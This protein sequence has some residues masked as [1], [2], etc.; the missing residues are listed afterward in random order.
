METADAQSKPNFAK[1]TDSQKFIDSIDDAEDLS[2]DVLYHRVRNASEALVQWQNE[3]MD[4]DRF[5]EVTE[6]VG[7]TA[8]PHKNP[9]IPKDTQIGIGYR[10][11]LE[12]FVYGFEYQYHQTKVGKQNPSRQRYT[13][14][15]NGGRELRQRFP[16]QKAV[17]ADLS[18]SPDSDEGIGTRRRGRG[19]KLRE[20][21]ADVDSAGSR[22][23]RGRNNSRI[24]SQSRDQTPASTFPSGK[25]R[26]RPAK[27]KAGGA[28][29][30]Q[31][32]QLEEGF[33]YDSTPEPSH[34]QHTPNY[35][36]NPGSLA[37]RRS[38]G[39]HETLETTENWHDDTEQDEPASRP[40]TSDST[41]TGPS[42]DMRNPP[43][44]SSGRGR[45]RQNTSDFED[46]L[47]SHKRIRKINHPTA[48]GFSDLD[49]A[50]STKDGSNAE[51]TRNTRR[52]RQEED[53]LPG[54]LAA[55]EDTLAGSI[56]RLQDTQ[57]IRA[58]SGSKIESTI[59]KN[60]SGK[61]RKIITLKTSNG[62]PRTPANAVLARNATTDP[63]PGTSAQ[64][65]GKDGPKVSRASLN[66][67]RRWAAKKQAEALGL[68]VPKIGR[69]P[70]GG[71]APSTPDVAG[72][73]DPFNS[74]K[75]LG[76]RKRKRDEEE[77]NAANV[78]VSDAVA[79]TVEAPVIIKKR[80]GRPRKVANMEPPNVESTGQHM[81]LGG[82]RSNTLPSDK[83][84]TNLEEP[85]LEIVPKRKGGRPRKKPVE[86]DEGT[87]GT[88]NPVQD[89]QEGV[90]QNQQSS[91][92]SNDSHGKTEDTTAV[93][94]PQDA[95]S[96]NDEDLGSAA[97][98]EETVAPPQLRRTTRVRRQTS[99]ALSASSQANTRRSSRSS[100]K[101]TVTPTPAPTQQLAEETVIKQ[102]TVAGPALPRKRGRKPKSAK[103]D[104]TPDAT[105]IAT[106]VTEDEAPPPKRRKVTRT[107]TVMSTGSTPAPATASEEERATPQEESTVVQKPGTRKRNASIPDTPAP[108]VLS[109]GQATSAEPSL[110]RNRARKTPIT[111]TPVV[112]APSATPG[113]SVE[114]SVPKKRPGRPR[115]NPDVGATSGLLTDV[116]VKAEDVTRLPEPLTTRARS[117]GQ[118][119][120][121]K[122][123]PTEDF[124]TGRQA[125]DP[126]PPRKKGN[127]GGKRV[128]GVFSSGVVPKP[129]VA[130]GSDA[131]TGADGVE[132]QAQSKKL[133]ALDTTIQEAPKRGSLGG[134]RNK[135]AL[136]M[137]AAPSGVNDSAAGST[138]SAPVSPSRPKRV[139]SKVAAPTGEVGIH[140]EVSETS[141][142]APSRLKRVVTVAD[143]YAGETNL[144]SVV[145]GVLSSPPP[146]PRRAVTTT[147]APRG[148]ITI[149][150]TFPIAPST[151]PSRSKRAVPVA[152]GPEEAGEAD[153]DEAVPGG[154]SNAPSRPKRVVTMKISPAGALAA[155]DSETSPNA[156]IATESITTEPNRKVEGGKGTWGGRR[157]K[158]AKAPSLTVDE[159]I[160]TK[161]ES[162]NEDSDSEAT[163]KEKKKLAA[164]ASKSLKNSQSMKGKHLII[165][166]CGLF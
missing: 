1:L 37:R 121:A 10:D 46:A 22:A 19:Q 31:E 129:V 11:E 44:R 71:S 120:A 128:K 78:G 76:G 117:S 61:E 8:K 43:A 23:Q 94:L 115:K 2:Y 111:G 125:T 48:N 73:P 154:P 106:N 47:P 127:W 95:Q 27:P 32:L 155:D 157:V 28:S 114:P 4:L 34:D 64:Q 20:G 116:P 105:V 66:M 107:T 98:E 126:E 139:N 141:S 17:E 60:Q 166:F 119:T 26:G 110:T 146:R 151:V 147:V 3:W 164:K 59:Q 142:N 50:Q 16:T 148:E 88:E 56:S 7:T 80:G 144:D 136:P 90:R 25:K 93:A 131:N 137:P 86:I 145:A 30:L 58:S 100:Q 103:V 102:E 150:D 96:A 51:K 123:N 109:D 85:V 138:A 72:V 153:I 112:Y 159:D 91:L 36:E 5:I 83:E 101:S 70:K 124:T 163:R 108:E 13:N 52:G 68:P 133:S 74:P 84:D 21:T 14:G 161:V 54:V 104:T 162:D 122:V 55:S 135:N 12:S 38:Y 99:A 143:A 87:M 45:K 149:D 118:D 156:I 132:E 62:I 39:F 82:D 42:D 89:T 6:P 92:D 134:F 79:V 77:P 24:D 9:R 65:D 33:E 49:L 63:L 15:A 158:S 165:F 67:M 140:D 35:T 18:T 40:G 57:E 53:V 113:S 130:S 29:R 75:P 41:M 160:A 152:V 69:Y 81:I 97:N